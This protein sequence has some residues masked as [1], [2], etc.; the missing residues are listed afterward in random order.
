MENPVGV[1]IPQNGNF[2]RHRKVPMVFLFRCMEIERTVLNTQYS[3]GSQFLLG[4]FVQGPSWIESSG[5]IVN[6]RYFLKSNCTIKTATQNPPAKVNFLCCFVSIYKGT[7]VRFPFPGLTCCRYY[8]VANT[9]SCVSVSEAVYICHIS[10]P[11][12]CFLDWSSGKEDT[13]TVFLCF[14]FTSPRVNLR[15]E[16]RTTVFFV[17]LFY[18][19]PRESTKGG[20]NNSFFVFLFLPLPSWI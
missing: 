4:Y 10:F 17:F 12:T 13:T 5:R 6:A 14:F 2:R 9:A 16:D 18:L 8:R 19:S 7:V 15:K 11:L 20:H 1:S 3:I